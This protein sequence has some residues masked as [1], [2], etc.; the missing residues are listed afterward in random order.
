M[1]GNQRM[2][3]IC[4]RCKRY[5][6]PEL[7]KSISTQASY[8]RLYQRSY[9]DVLGVKRSSSQTEIKAAYFE[10]SKVHHP[11]RVDVTCHEKFVEIGKAYE[12]LG[13]PLSRQIYDRTLISPIIG[14]ANVR[15][16]ATTTNPFGDDEEVDW[17]KAHV[18]D[19]DKYKQPRDPNSFYGIRGIPKIP[20][21]TLIFGLL[22]FAAVGGLAQFIFV[23]AISDYRR[24]QLDVR[25]RQI[26]MVLQELDR[27]MK[28]KNLEKQGLTSN[29]VNLMETN[30][31]RA[32]SEGVEDL[33]ETAKKF[34]Y[35][36]YY[37]YPV[38]R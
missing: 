14:G 12:I 33:D 31:K 35:N 22:I 9:Y 7:K 21:M 27:N 1:I 3:A 20:N 38:Q 23:F 13:K 15:Y 25:D 36:T 18:F 37:S 6:S 30:H 17:F 8:F 28:L 26:S 4:S 19:E 24:N 2:L 32:A 5:L 11:D 10:L 16:T 29:V 34:R